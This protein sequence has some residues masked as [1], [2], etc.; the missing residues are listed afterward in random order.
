MG[1]KSNTASHWGS[2]AR[3]GQRRHNEFLSSKVEPDASA[4]QFLVSLMIPVADVQSDPARPPFLSLSIYKRRTRRASNQVTLSGG[5]GRGRAGPKN[6]EQLL[7]RHRF[8]FLDELQKSLVF[9]RFCKKGESSR[10][11]RGLAH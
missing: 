1:P 2:G 3:R 8:R 4:G 6:G 5:S 7:G 11:D 9:E 10:I